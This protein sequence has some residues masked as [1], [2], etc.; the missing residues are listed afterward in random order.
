VTKGLSFTLLIVFCLSNGM[1]CGVRTGWQGAAASPS[2]DRVKTLKIHGIHGRS[3]GTIHEAV[4]P[5]QMNDISSSV[6]KD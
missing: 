6:Q 1:C 4:N 3:G 5:S 2:P